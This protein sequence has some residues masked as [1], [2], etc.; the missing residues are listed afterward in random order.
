MLI[1]N[2]IFVMLILLVIQILIGFIGGIFFGILLF[3]EIN[4]IIMFTIVLTEIVY[5]VYGFS[6]DKK[7]EVKIKIDLGLDGK[8]ILLMLWFSLFFQFF[9]SELEISMSNVI[10]RIEFLENDLAFISELD[11][12]NDLMLAIFSVALMPAF[13]EEILF[14]GI[15]QNS[16]SLVY[17][18][19]NAIVISSFAFAIIHLNPATMPSIFLLSLA[20]GY[21]YHETRNI[22]YPML[23]HAFNNLTAILFFKVDNLDLIK[24][25]NPRATEY[26]RNFFWILAVLMTYKLFAKILIRLDRSEN[27]NA[28]EDEVLP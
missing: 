12:A 20:A 17:G 8:L 26:L 18:C 19:G 25:I 5:L 15:I 6:L 23:L 16:L 3:G 10:G 27:I 11:G 22:I 7:Y 21:I 2:L 13:C 28:K 24:I 14:R 4:K 1:K 9:L